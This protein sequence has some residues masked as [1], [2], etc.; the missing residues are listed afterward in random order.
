MNT[1]TKTKTNDTADRE[2]WLRDRKKGIGGSDVAAVL[3]LSP[4]RTPLDVFNDK[5]AET[6][7]EK[8]Q[9]EAAHFGTILEDVVADEFARRTGF[10]VARFTKTL[11]QNP[12]CHTGG[13]GWARANLDRVIVN[14]AIAKTVR[15]TSE[16][17]HALQA[18]CFTRG[19][20]LT[21]DA[22][23]ECKTASAYASDLWGPSQEAEIRAGEVVTE[24]KIPI[25]YETQVQ[26]YLGLTGA[27]VCY[28]AVLIGGN[29]FRIY[30][31]KP[32]RELFEAICEKC[33]AFWSGHVLTGE[34]PAATNVEDVRKLFAKD[35]GEMVEATNEVA[36]TIGELRT[37][38]ARIKE[39]KDEQEALEQ[40]LIVALG[41]RTGFLIG[42]EKAVTYKTQTVN[43]FDTTAFK[44]A[45]PA[46]YAEYVKTNTTRVLRVS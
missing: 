15:F 38:K 1:M 8:P 41:E 39:L 16:A 31:V 45:D 5:T 21:T 30:A 22:I 28:V 43:R 34:P 13:V 26:W 29:D 10:K 27:K 9:S 35:S 46:T 7:D 37:V 2:V 33:W 11:S 3:G 44:K 20:W 40:S 23:L 6:V 24:H 14:P 4:W 25:Y 32:D 36:T 18:K 17:S 12:G 42:G 19:L